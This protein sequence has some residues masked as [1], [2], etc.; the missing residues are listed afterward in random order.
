[1]TNLLD[2][3]TNILRQERLPHAQEISVLKH[4]HY[5]DDMDGLPDIEMLFGGEDEVVFSFRSVGGHHLLSVD[6]DGDVF[7]SFS[8]FNYHDGR[9]TFYD[10]GQYSV[11]DVI[12]DFLRD[13]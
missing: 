3:F 1:M 2:K 7:V 13:V 6:S 11:N 5:M 8:G 9:R 4:I 12:S 10:H